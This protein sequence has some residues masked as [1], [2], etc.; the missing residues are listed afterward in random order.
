VQFGLNKPVARE[1]D[2]EEGEYRLSYKI[3][4][5]LY[6]RG[7]RGEECNMMNLKLADRRKVLKR[8]V[9]TIPMHVE[10]VEVVETSNFDDIITAFD[11]AVLKNE[12]GIIIK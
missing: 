3:F 1:G 6:V 2:H 12:E 9:R 5:I 7:F 8:V 10:L 11:K 4:D